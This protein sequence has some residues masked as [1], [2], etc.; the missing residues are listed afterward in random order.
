[1]VSYPWEQEFAPA[2]VSPPWEDDRFRLNSDEEDAD[3]MS[4]SP[5]SAADELANFLIDLNVK[6]GEKAVSANHTCIHAW[7]AT[8]AALGGLLSDFALH[9]FSSSGHYQR[10]LDSAF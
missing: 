5:E 2:P 6:N 9:P 1:M 7:W 10:K 3:P 4:P 8:K